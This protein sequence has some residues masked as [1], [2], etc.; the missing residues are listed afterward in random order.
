MSRATT[1]FSS[2]PRSDSI[3]TTPTRSRSCTCTVSLSHTCTKHTSY[4]DKIAQKEKEAQA[5]DEQ[6]AK[7]DGVINTQRDFSNELLGQPMSR[8][9][10]DK[11]LSDINDGLI[12]V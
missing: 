8:E 3:L 12:Q 10:I 11:A 2:P 9:E 6:L 5:L 1:P 7:K 4:L